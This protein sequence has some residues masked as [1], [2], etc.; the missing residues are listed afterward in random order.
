MSRAKKRDVAG[1]GDE[2]L[3]NSVLA[4]LTRE[5]QQNSKTDTGTDVTMLFCG[6]K[7]SGKTTLIDRWMNPTKEESQPKPTVALDYKF[8]RYASDNS[9]TKALAHLYEL[10]GDENNDD[11][12][13]IP[14]S[15]CTVSNLVLAIVV[16]LSEPHSVLATLEKWITLLNVQTVKSL[17]TLSRESQV[18]AQRV[19]SIRA[20]RQEQYI[21]HPDVNVIR[22]IP[23]QTVIFGS[24]WDLFASDTDPE[25]RK[26]ICRALRYFAHV[27]GASLVFTSSKDKASMNNARSIIRQLLFGVTVKGG[28][29]EQFDPSKP[30]C[31]QAGKEF[32]PNIGAPQGGY[33]TDSGWRD[34][35]NDLFPDPHRLN[36]DG[37]KSDAGLVAEELQ[38]YPESSIDGMVEQRLE[39]LQ[40]YRRQVERNQRLAS[41]GIDGRKD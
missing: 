6:S 11:L 22:P 10:G 9:T 12:A 1:K 21:E 31:I 29:P 33:P 41:E 20:A 5:F 24:K 3:E 16:D 26:A 25:K 30:L 23:V 18:G 15:A 28:V 27:N 36:K 34:L 35:I 2:D 19:E 13:A 17:E 38:K 32:M 7:R 14:V 4:R 39:E 40:Q 8:A 37:K